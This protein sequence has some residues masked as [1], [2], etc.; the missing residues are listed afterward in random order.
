MS[1]KIT[2]AKKKRTHNRI[3]VSIPVYQ[4]SYFKGDV[5][6]LPPNSTYRLTIDYPLYEKRS[7]EIKTGKSGMGLGALIRAIGKCYEKACENDDNVWG[8]SIDDLFLEEIK[9]NHSKK[10]IIVDVS[11]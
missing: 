5:D 2:Q 1:K 10:M 11:S 6:K 3:T 8:H 4:L 7:Y 9:I